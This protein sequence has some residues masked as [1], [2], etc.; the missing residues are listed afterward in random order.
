MI[1]NGLA[2]ELALA[3]ATREPARAA[4]VDDRLGTLEAGKF[5]DVVAVQGN[6]LDDIEALLR[7]EAVWKDGKPVRLAPRLSD[8]GAHAPAE[9]EAQAVASS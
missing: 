1:Q 3:A 4:R 9:Q 6:P 5:A 7:V 2:P 8:D